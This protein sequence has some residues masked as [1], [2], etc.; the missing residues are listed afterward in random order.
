MT[1][2]NLEKRI[3]ELEQKQLPIK[4]YPICYALDEDPEIAVAKHKKKYPD[5]HGHLHVVVYAKPVK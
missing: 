4:R 3:K 5:C 2:F 1:K